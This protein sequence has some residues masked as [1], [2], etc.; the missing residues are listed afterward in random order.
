MLTTLILAGFSLIALLSW[1]QVLLKANSDSDGGSIA[2]G[3]LTFLLLF[4]FT[5]VSV[6]R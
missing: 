6:S 3:I 2:L 5:M 4:A 1:V